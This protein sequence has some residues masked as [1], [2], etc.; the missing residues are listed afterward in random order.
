MPS[1]S[2]FLKRVPVAVAVGEV[3]EPPIGLEGAGQKIG[4]KN[5]DRRTKKS[6]ARLSDAGA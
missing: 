2:K 5:L 6:I 1:G 3:M 4:P